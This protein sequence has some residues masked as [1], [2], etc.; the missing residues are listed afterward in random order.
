MIIP[1]IQREGRKHTYVIPPERM[2]V[3]DS[4]TFGSRFIIS[5]CGEKCFLSITEVSPHSHPHFLVPPQVASQTPTKFDRSKD[6]PSSNRMF[7]FLVLGFWCSPT[8]VLYGLS[9]LL[10]VLTPPPPPPRQWPDSF[11]IENT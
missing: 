4:Q 11:G 7:S 3:N 1:E 10:A 2:S 5:E 6:F 9:S 8:V